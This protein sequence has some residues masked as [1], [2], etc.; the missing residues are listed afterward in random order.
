[1]LPFTHAQ[2]I[3]VFARYNTNVWP[4]QVLAYILGLG[5]VLALLRSSAGTGRGVSVGLAVMW[6][7]TGIAYHGLHFAEI[8]KAAFL[9]GA[10]FVIEGLLLLRAGFAGTLRFGASRGAAAWLGWGLILYAT[11]LYPLLGLWAGHRFTEM[12][13][14]GITPCPVTIFT[15]GVFL[16]ATAPV[17]RW[18]LVI[19]VIWSLIG[20]SAAFLLQVP[21]DWLLLFSGLSVVPL[22]RSGARAALKLQPR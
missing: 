4:A 22:L 21:Q 20:G 18:L 10:L 2:F 11:L 9:F 13:M 12:P 7:W 19:P 3:E 17:S 1:M 14:F 8:N 6:L 5:I 15:F 16:L